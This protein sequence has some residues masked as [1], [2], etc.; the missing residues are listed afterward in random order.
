MGPVTLWNL[1]FVAELLVGAALVAL[2]VWAYLRFT[3]RYRQQRKQLNT[4]RS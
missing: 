4:N 3:R 2:I 1:L